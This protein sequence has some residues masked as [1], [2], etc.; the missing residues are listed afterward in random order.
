LAQVRPTS[1]DQD[2]V[3][4]ARAAIAEGAT[5]LG[6]A[7]GDSTVSA[8]AVVA[9]EAQRPL[10]VIP[11]GTRNHFARDLG[12]NI[13]NPASALTALRAADTARVNL[14]RVGLPR[15]TAR[16]RHA[17]RSCQLTDLGTG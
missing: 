5:V 3:S 4:L 10:M 17:G 1:P 2:A 11:A 7:G 9:A 12:L 13:R 14:G 8:V 6:V 16:H 15:Q